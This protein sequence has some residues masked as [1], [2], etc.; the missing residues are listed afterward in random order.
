[1]VALSLLE[2]LRDT[3]YLGL[4]LIRACEGR[5]L[6]G[7]DDVANAVWCAFLSSELCT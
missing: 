6:V 2:T 4:F 7:S 3:T 5:I 1:M